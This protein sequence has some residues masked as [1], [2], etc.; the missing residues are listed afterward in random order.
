LNISRV[1]GIVRQQAVLMLWQAQRWT[2]DQYLGKL[3]H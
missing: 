3:I 2:H 1:P